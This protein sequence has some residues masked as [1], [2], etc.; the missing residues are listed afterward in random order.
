MISSI[1]DTTGDAVSEYTTGDSVSEDVD[2]IVDTVS[3][4]VEHI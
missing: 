3:E 4:D 1:A 2:A